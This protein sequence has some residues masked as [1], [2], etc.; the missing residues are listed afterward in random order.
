MCGR[1]FYKSSLKVQELK[2]GGIDFPGMIEGL[3]ELD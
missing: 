1:K 3:I 2:C